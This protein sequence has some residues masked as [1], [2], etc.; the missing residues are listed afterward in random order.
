LRQLLW[1]VLLGIMGRLSNF[2]GW[3]NPGPTDPP[4]PV[5]RPVHRHEIESGLRLILADESGLASDE[6]VLDFL[7]VAVQ[8]QMDLNQMWVAQSGKR[9][10]W[11]LLPVANPGKTVLMLTPPN[12]LPGTTPQ[13][14]RALTRI[15]CEHWRARG[16][17]LA[18]F[19]LPPGD[20]VLQQTYVSSG[21][22]TLAELLY[23]QR[24]AGKVVDV[25][26]GNGFK[27]HNYTPATHNDFAEAIGRSYEGSL[28]CPGL[29]GR[30]HIDD[31]IAGHQGTGAFEP[32]AWHVLVKDGRPCGVLILSPAQHNEVVELV[33]LGLTPEC[34]GQGLGDA[35][36][37]LAGNEVRRLER[38]ELSLAVDAANAPAVAL[39]Y[40]HGLRRVGSR[41][42]LLRDLHTPTPSLH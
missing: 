24:T 32:S 19:L 7:A 21:F 30:R 5:C 31:V 15:V 12:L 28:D 17:Q 35:L 29:N 39:Y 13:A 37:R 11:A 16:V 36:M 8:R 40:R 38:R 9:I 34:R 1:R 26:L 33:Y 27:L 18:Q 14:V 20:S 25:G 42:A 41:L 6:A 22:E 10:T 23:L 2:F 3:R 4:A